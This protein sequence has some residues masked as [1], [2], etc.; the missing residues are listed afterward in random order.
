MYIR[1]K[2]NV[3]S[4]IYA[5]NM[6]RALQTYIDMPFR[7]L[8]LLLLFYYFFI[9]FVILTPDLKNYMSLN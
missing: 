3:P 2:I 6:I 7:I 8:V 9:I 1:Y 5:R 4:S